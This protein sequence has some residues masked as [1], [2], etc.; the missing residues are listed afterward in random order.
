MSVH[1]ESRLACRGPGQTTAIAFL[2]GP[3]Q[4]E[5]VSSGD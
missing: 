5:W 1:V 4:E 2:L 3:G